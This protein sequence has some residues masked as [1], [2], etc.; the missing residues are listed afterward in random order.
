M[1]TNN[2]FPASEMAKAALNC[3]ELPMDTDMYE[4]FPV[5]KILPFWEYKFSGFKEKKEIRNSFARYVVYFYSPGLTCIEDLYP[6]HRARKFA[7]A[8]LAGFKIT[9]DRLDPKVED[10]LEGKNESCNQMVLS[11]LKRYGSDDWS[12]IKWLRDKY[13]ENMGKQ[14][15]MDGLEIQ[16]IKKAQDDIRD[17]IKVYFKGDTSKP[18]T[19]SLIERQEAEDLKLS[20]EAIAANIEQG[21]SPLGFSIS[22]I[23]NG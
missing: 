12:T 4:A 3:Y 20:P 9:D 15:E 22:D 17:L 21:K 23:M 6:E 8:E 2:K 11:F 5:L 14:T 13:Y 7:C 1:I 18:L 10:I 16:R 19:R